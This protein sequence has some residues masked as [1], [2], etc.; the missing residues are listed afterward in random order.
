M[1]LAHLVKMGTRFN[2]ETSKSWIHLSYTDDS[3]LL[4]TN[5][6][7]QVFV[8]TVISIH[9]VATRDTDKNQ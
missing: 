4:F 3:K 7:D 9:L 1:V 5:T 8:P 6:V 2:S